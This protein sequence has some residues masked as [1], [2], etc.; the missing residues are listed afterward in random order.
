VLL[1][2]LLVVGVLAGLWAGIVICC[3]LAVAIAVS[4]G[5]PR[6]PGTSDTRSGGPQEGPPLE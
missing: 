1:G 3:F 4:L 5:Q 6:E 2:V